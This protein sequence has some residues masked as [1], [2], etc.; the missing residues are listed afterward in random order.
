MNSDKIKELQI[1]PGEKKRPERSLAV[2]FLAV[3]L[4]TGLAVFFAWPRARD[5]V[6]V[7]NK[8]GSSANNPATGVST[9]STSELPVRASA[10]PGTNGDN[11]V[12]TVNGY[13]I[14]RERIELSPR[15]MGTVTWI[16]V[17]KGDA[18]TKGQIVVLLDDAEYKARLHEVE[19]RLATAKANVDKARLDYERMVQLNK[20]ATESKKAE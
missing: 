1:A 10:A 9:A 11:V 14:N 7:A 8:P 12:L 16:G 18:V 5:S 3:I 17:K 19:G 15:Y 13:I 2:I 6:R 4:I 20:T